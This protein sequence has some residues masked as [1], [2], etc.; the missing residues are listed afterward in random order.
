[1]THPVYRELTLEFYTTLK[2]LDQGHKKFECRLNRKLIII[3]YDTMLAVFG[4]QKEGF[5][6][7]QLGTNLKT[8]GERSLH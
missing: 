2:L 3:N 7:R 1:M 4:S 6:K 8:F 5:V